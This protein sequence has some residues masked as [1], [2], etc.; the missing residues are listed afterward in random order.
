MATSLACHAGDRATFLKIRG[1]LGKQLEDSL[2]N[3]YGP[4]ADYCDLKYG[5]TG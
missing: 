1:E 5:Y 3:E 4:N 2:W